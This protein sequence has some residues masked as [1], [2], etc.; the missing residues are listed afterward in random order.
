MVTFRKLLLWNPCSAF[1]SHPSAT[2]ENG[3]PEEVIGALSV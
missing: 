1:A 2:A 3:D